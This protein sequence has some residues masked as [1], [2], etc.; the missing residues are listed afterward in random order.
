MNWLRG[1]GFEYPHVSY[2]KES[3]ILNYFKSEY[4]FVDLGLPSGL[5]WA[6]CNIGAKEPWESGLCFAWGEDKG[7]QVT[8]GDVQDSNNG[9]YTTTITNADGTETTKM[10]L[11]DYSDYEHYNMETSTFTKYADTS[12]STLG[13]E[14]DGCYMTENAMRM[15]TSDECQ[16]LI[17]NTTSAWTTDY[18]GS[19]IAG[20]TLTAS[21]GNFI[22]VPAV[23]IVDEGTLY[24]FGLHGFFWSSSLYSNPKKAF[25]F[26]CNSVGAD[27]NR[28]S[29]ISGLPL[30]AV[31]P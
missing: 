30:R 6:T 4:E 1:G 29:R 12:V 23:G 8:K 24:F 9:I 22:F 3:G 21:N 15:P 10:F 19:G 28:S 18:N 2:I 31:R 13:S 5:R 26:G 27:V 17:E 16:E 20:C 14:D 11:Q 7:Y 25:S